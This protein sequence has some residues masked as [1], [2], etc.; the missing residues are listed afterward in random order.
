ML[1]S[2]D[3]GWCDCVYVAANSYWGP[4]ELEL[5]EP[6]P[7]TSWRLFADTGAAA[8]G[9]VAEPGT[10]PRLVDQSRIFIAPRAVLVLTAAPDLEQN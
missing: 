2:T 7:H 3:S 9:D 6:P 10:E 8:P 1:Y 5:P 4:L